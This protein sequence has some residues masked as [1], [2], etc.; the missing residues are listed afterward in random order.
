[1][2]QHVTNPKGSLKL[3]YLKDGSD[4][5]HLG[6]FCSSSVPP[7]LT[8]YSPFYQELSLAEGFNI[9]DGSVSIKCPE[10]D[11]NNR[12]IVVCESL[13]HSTVR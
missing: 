2:P 12:Y 11:P 3:G 5:E 9:K 6:E 8:Y 10:V 1:M 13:R 7:L 4:D